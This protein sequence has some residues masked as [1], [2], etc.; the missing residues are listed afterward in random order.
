MYAYDIIEAFTEQNVPLKLLGLLRSKLE[1]PRSRTLVLAAVIIIIAKDELINKLK[2]CIERMNQQATGPI[3]VPPNKKGGKN[4]TIN[5]TNHS[6]NRHS[7]LL[8][9][10]PQQVIVDTLNL[11]LGLSAYSEDC[12]NTELKRVILASFPRC[13]NEREC[14]KSLYKKLNAALFFQLLYGICKLTQLDITLDAKTR[15]LLSFDGSGSYSSSNSLPSVGP[16]SP[17]SPKRHSGTH[18]DL[19]DTVS[20]ISPSS[21]YSGGSSNSLSSLSGTYTP[22]HSSRACM[23]EPRDI[24][25]KGLA[26]F[27]ENCKLTVP[28]VNAEN[29]MQTPET[30]PHPTHSTFS[31]SRSISI[32]NPSPSRPAEVELQTDWIAVDAIPSP[33]GTPQTQPQQA[34]PSTSPVADL[35]STFKWYKKKVEVSISKLAQK[36]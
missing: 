24:S 18:M 5:V 36:K 20:R 34:K 28:L 9:V 17:S 29:L 15:L 16:S 14:E 23:L 30:Q 3:P 32:G 2:K 1:E 19:S 7:V 6:S 13:L 31:A 27:L 12:Y 35:A 25:S 21:S 11:M 8:D 22:P 10:T 26:V 4:M 33:K